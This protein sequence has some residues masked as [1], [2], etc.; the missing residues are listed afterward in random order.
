[1]SECLCALLMVVMLGN[2][3]LTARGIYSQPTHCAKG[4]FTVLGARTMRVRWT[5][6]RQ[7]YI[8][9]IFF[10]PPPI[11]GQF[12]VYYCWGNTTAIIGNQEVP[13]QLESKPIRLSK[14]EES[15]CTTSS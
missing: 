7:Q 9:T 5:N 12:Q 8:V 14:M 4:R 2:Y 6:L 1:M 15:R 3:D 10:P 11:V 13:V